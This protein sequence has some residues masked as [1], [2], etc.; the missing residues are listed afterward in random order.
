MTQSHW[1][2]VVDGLIVEH[3]ANR[4]DLGTARQLGWMPPTPVYL[5]KMVRAKRHLVRRLAS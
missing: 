2:R 3:W 4:D 1:F 5:V